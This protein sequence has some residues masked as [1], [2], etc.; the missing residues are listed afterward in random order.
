MAKIGINLKTG[1]VIKDSNVIV[2]IDLGTTNSLVAYIKEEEAVA[3]K[4]KDGKNTLVPSVI[5]FEEA[6]FQIVCLEV[7]FL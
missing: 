2:G 1:S 3:V 7:A 5:H 4:D 6:I